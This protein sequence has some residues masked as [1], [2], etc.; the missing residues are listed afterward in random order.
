MKIISIEKLYDYNYSIVPVNSMK[1]HWR[2]YNTFGC[3]G[4]PKSQNILL[5]LNGCKAEYTLKDNTKIAAKSGDIVY[6]PINC[7]YSVRFY[8]FDCTESHTIGVN[9][10][11]YDDE[12]QP[13]I[14]SEDILVF[15]GKEFC[16]PQFI[17]IDASYETPVLCPSK[18]KA[19]MYD[20]FSFLSEANRNK[21]IIRERY[22]IIAEGIR[23]M[24]QNELQEKSI[25]EVARMCNV[26]EIYF[27]RLFKEYSGM[28]P[29]QY[30]INS[31]IERAKLYLE[32]ENMSS[33]EIAER[34]GFISS[35]YFTRQFK[36]IT[37]M[38]PLEY[39]KSRWCDKATLH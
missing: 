17:K 13:F 5:Y 31:K 12:N 21:K 37:K 11:L 6:T 14:L 32:Y 7:E 27:R 26:S 4:K 3:F 39:K 29:I 8:D 24:E 16:A 15:P 9:F 1:Q 34:L 33:R 38:T 25:A 36:T 22:G 2:L 18:M 30:R 28:S 20:I 10:F 19:A 23:Y 35:A